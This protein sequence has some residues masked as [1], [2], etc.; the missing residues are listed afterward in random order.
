MRES[1]DNRECPFP[2][3]AVRVKSN[4]EQV[5]SNQ[6]HGAGLEQYLPSYRSQRRWS[7]RLKEI[8]VPLFPGYV[9]ARFNL[10]DR[11]PLLRL[12]GVVGIVGFGRQP[13]PIPEEE[14]SAVRRMLSCSSDCL[15]WPFLRA[16]ELVQ[17][18][19][20]PLAGLQGIFVQTKGRYRLVVSVDLLQRSVG[21][22]VDR[23]SV[24]PL[25]GL[26]PQ[27]GIDTKGLAA[28][29]YFSPS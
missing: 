10:G 27:A 15:P 24:R 12:S 17:I 2:W 5:V 18:Q 26:L 20:G 19:H 25:K 14:I 29:S 1:L 8:D 16:G 13:A 21:V 23:D 9:F 28:S 22:E 7:D 4:C 3:Y 6:L 11:I